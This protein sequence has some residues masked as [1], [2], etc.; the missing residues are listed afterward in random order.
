MD[1]YSIGEMVIDFIPGCESDSYVRSAGGAPANVAIMVARSGLSAGMCCMVGQDEFGRFLLDTLREHRVEVLVPRMCEEAV[2]T[3][4]FVSLGPDGDR[5]FTFARKPGA[6]MFLSESDV[7]EA[8][9]DRAVIIH[10]GSCSLSAPAAASATI[11]ALRLGHERGRLV[12]FDVNYRDVMW[13][14]GPRTW[15]EQVAA[16]LPYVDFV[17]CSGDEWPMFG[18]GDP[19]AWMAQFGVSLLVETRGADGARCFYGG[20]VIE[21]PGRPAV[22]VDATGAGDA[23]W[24]AFLSELRIQGVS[25]L[26]DLTDERLRRAMVCGNVAGWLCV[27]RKGAIAALPDRAQIERYL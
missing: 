11:R 22:C 6:D 16:V 13:P 18:A 12:S 20:R 21:I 14:S 5:R 10:A 2:T 15:A 7:R 4:A 24:G 9:I 23:F 19:F 8:D 1:V 25:E 27:Q 3:M 17:K 26:A